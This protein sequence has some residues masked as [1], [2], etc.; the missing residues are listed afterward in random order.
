MLPRWK[1]EKSKSFRG[2]TP[3]QETVPKCILD[4]QNVDAK[5]APCIQSGTQEIPSSIVSFNA[6]ILIGCFCKKDKGCQNRI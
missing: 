4:T 2:S 1:T 3:K 6:N 5:K